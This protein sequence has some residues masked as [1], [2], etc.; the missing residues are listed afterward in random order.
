MR[1]HYGIDFSL[2]YSTLI[3]TSNTPGSPVPFRSAVAVSLM[4]L[5]SR[6]YRETVTG[7]ATTFKI[8]A[9]P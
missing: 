6:K 5:P 4:Q 2:R 1:L 9:Q 7:L 8:E 3:K